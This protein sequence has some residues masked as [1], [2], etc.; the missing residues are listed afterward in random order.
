MQFLISYVGRR[1]EHCFA[2]QREVLPPRPSEDGGGKNA[3][4][5]GSHSPIAKQTLRWRLGR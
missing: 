5:A 2:E 4:A 3:E 1:E